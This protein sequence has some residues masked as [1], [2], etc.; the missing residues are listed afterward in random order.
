MGRDKASLLFSGET[1]LAR[2]VRIAA[3][4]APAENIVV[5]AAQGQAPGRAQQVA[6]IHD[7]EPAQ[8]PLMAVA[9]GLQ[10]LVERVD[11]AFV[12][13]CDAP[14]LKPEL[15]DRLYCL[16]EQDPACDAVVPLVDG[17]LCPL[18]AVYR[19]RCHAPLQEAVAAGRRSLQRALA[20]GTLRVR[21]VA[22]EELRAVDPGL[23]SFLNCNT[24]EELE[25]A[26]RRSTLAGDL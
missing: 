17:R 22:V 16:L 13:G 14:L 3:G 4:A 18:T 10:F 9:A 21:Q 26:R 24:P 23:D 19:T 25:A 6:V 5:V 7:K 12:T 15:V 8:G 2:T 20:G 11:V 1:L